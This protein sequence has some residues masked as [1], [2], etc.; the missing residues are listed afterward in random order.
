MSCKDTAVFRKRGRGPSAHL[1]LKRHVWKQRVSTSTQNRHFK[2]EITN[3]LWGTLSWHF[4]DTSQTHG[5][6]W[7]YNTSWK[8]GHKRCPLNLFN[9]ILVISV[10][11]LKIY[12]TTTSK[13][14]KIPQSSKYAYLMHKN[15]WGLFSCVKQV[16]LC[17]S[18]LNMMC[19]MY[20]L[21]S[22]FIC[23]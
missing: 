19:S 8:K 11:P 3:D 12:S 14:K 7:D 5:D 23:E 15:Q 6:T 16:Q 13:A 18:F 17:I 22:M 4:T 21:W 9:E 2:N 20:V 1:H 10:P